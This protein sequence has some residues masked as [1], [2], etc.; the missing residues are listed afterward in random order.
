MKTLYVTNRAD[1]REWLQNN[2]D[3]EKEIWLVYPAKSS[4]RPRI[5]YNEAVEEALSF[6]WID[7]TVKSVGGDSSAQR[8]SPRRPD[9]SFSQSNKERIKWLYQ[10]GMLHPATLDTAQKIIKENFVFPP[11]IIEEIKKDKLAW[12]NYSKFSEAYKRIRIAYVDAARKR[13][14]E[15]RKRLNNFV[16]KTRANKLI[17]FGGIE[18]YY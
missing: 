9:S 10:K 8:F 3:K 17:G 12:K 7:S 13:P 2:F 16:E 11:D 5:Q 4:G 15:F 14:G 6:G 1:W 18:K